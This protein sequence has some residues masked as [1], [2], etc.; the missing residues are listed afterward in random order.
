MNIIGD[1]INV[2]QRIMGFARPGQLLVSRSFYEVVSRLSRDYERLFFHEGS[3]TDKHVRAHEVYSVGS[4]I[5]AGRRVVDTVARMRDTNGGK[6]WL[7]ATGPLGLH[8]AALLAA[9]LAF[10]VL[11]GV[12]AAVRGKQRSEIATAAPAT[13]VPAAAAKEVPSPEVKTAAPPPAPAKPAPAPT[14]PPRERKA[15]A[16]AAVAARPEVH[17][18]SHETAV[19]LGTIRLAVAPW[20]QVLVDGKER[21]VSPPLTEIKIAAGAHTVEIRNTTFASHVAKVHV[22]AGESVTIKHRFR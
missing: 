15:R 12:G 17:R 7:S 19:K 14:K 11:V 10:L 16:A 21:G 9:S 1:G 8:R 6:K 4:G 18:P 2:A 20:G 22:K 5:P 3:R 13:Q